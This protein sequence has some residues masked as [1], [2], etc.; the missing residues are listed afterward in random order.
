MR[1]RQ[2]AVAARA[3]SSSRW[4]RR[5]ARFQRGRKCRGGRR[6]AGKAAARAAPLRHRDDPCQERPCGLREGCAEEARQAV[7]PPLRGATSAHR[8]AGKRFG[9]LCRGREGTCAPHRR[10]AGPCVLLVVA[11]GPAASFRAGRAKS[12]AGR[13][14]A[15]GTAV[16]HTLAATRA[17]PYRRRA[18]AQPWT[19]TARSPPGVGAALAL[20]PVPAWA[21]RSTS[22][23]R[24]VVIWVRHTGQRLLCRRRA[25]AH[26]SHMHMCL[27]GGWWS[28][29]AQMRA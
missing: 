21:L 10:D 14:R 5:T 28:G 20:A 24:N 17:G 8:R 22:T 15:G 18:P 4:C 2:P 29:R 9:A 19:G 26:S 1:A 13:R 16:T 25:L 27:G 23:C 12:P 11:L 7:P 3:R 6:R